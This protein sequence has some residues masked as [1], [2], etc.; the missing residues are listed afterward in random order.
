[1]QENMPND[2]IGTEFRVRT[3]SNLASLV[4]F[5]AIMT[6]LIGFMAIVIAI[7]VKTEM[8]TL[9]MIATIIVGMVSAFFAIRFT[10][11]HVLAQ[12]L[13]ITLSPDSIKISCEYKPFFER[14]LDDHIAMDEVAAYKVYTHPAPRLKIYLRTGRKLLLAGNNIGDNS[15]LLS[16]VNA[17]AEMAENRKTTQGKAAS[18]IRKKTIYEGA[19]GMALAIFFMVLI[20]ATF[21][22]IL[23]M[24]PHKTK[25]VVFA[26]G[27]AAM[28]MGYVFYIFS[29]RKKKKDEQEQE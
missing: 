25:D 29:I 19:S 21:Y 14:R 12:K 7:A 8:S 18:I 16:F 6:I 23:F 13:M 1:M 20:G 22:A 3:V 10:L 2:S 27:Y 17:F 26:L 9:V 5:F 15:Q 28:G 24:G 4:A 11:L